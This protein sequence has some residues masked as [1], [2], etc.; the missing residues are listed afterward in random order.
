LV[1]RTSMSVEIGVVPARQPRGALTQRSPLLL[2]RINEVMREGR[3]GRKEAEWIPFFCECER[4]D[5][6]EP[7]WLSADAYDERR[8][9]AQRPLILPGH[10]HEHEHRG[11]HGAQLQR[12]S[13]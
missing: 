2:R 11:A 6:Y 4:D 3:R 8:T 12:A 7:F 9:E 13:R 5:C 10:E 1:A